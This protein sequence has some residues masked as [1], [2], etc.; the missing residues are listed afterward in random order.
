MDLTPTPDQ[1]TLL[2]MTAQWCRDKMPIET[3]RTRVPA[4]W[5]EM[6]TMGWTR[7][8]CSETGLDHAAEALIFAELGRHLAPVTLIS[9]AVANSCLFDEPGR[10]KT[11][12][13]IV[14]PAPDSGKV[15]VCDPDGATSA[16]AWD[17][18]GL[19]LLDLP[20]RL[21]AGPGLD[22]TTPLAVLDPAPPAAPIAAPHAALQFRLLSAALALGCADAALD[23]ASEYA[24]LREQ[25]GRPIGWFQAIKHMC[26]DA[27]TRCAV[28]RSQLYLAAASLDA[29]TVDAS[30]QI[31]AAKRLADQAAI[32]NARA[33]IQIHGGIGIT[34]EAYPHLC[35][36]RAH[37][38]SFT[39]PVNHDSLLGEI[40]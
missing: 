40:A 30:F 34:D 26:A 10:G 13:A 16:I 9:T 2:E 5:D 21:A 23:M 22:P 38:L 8:T 3:A 32:A 12:L 39:A 27:A 11:A 33:N 19:M 24:K 18:A 6:E 35:L 14:S 28:A 29:R 1:L 20:G 31:A 36:K 25:F 15:R 4:L 7:L 37:L 17:E